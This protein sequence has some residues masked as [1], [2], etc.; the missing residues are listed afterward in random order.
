MDHIFRILGPDKKDYV[1]LTGSLPS[2]EAEN[3][4]ATLS[5]DCFN[6]LMTQVFTFHIDLTSTV[7]MVTENGR[8]YRLNRENIILDYNLEVLLTVFF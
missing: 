1:H 5:F 4:F 7:A 3:Y 8:Q 6:R 2:S